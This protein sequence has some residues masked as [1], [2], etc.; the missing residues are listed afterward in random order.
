MSELSPPPK[1]I[2]AARKAA[3]ASLVGS[4]VEWYDYFIFG[5]AS[6]LVFGKLFFPESTP[7]VGTLASFAAF[8][9]GFL[10]RPLGGV[11][12]GAFGDRIGRKKILVI[13]LLI[14]GF[15]TTGIGLLPGTEQIGILAPILLVVLRLAQGFGVGGEWGGAALIAVEHAPANKKARFGSVAQMGVGIGVV[16]SAGA[17]AAMQALTTDEQFLSWGWRIP[18]LLSFVL[19]LVGFWIRRNITESPEFVELQEQG[20]ITETPVKETLTKN[21]GALW[22]ALGMRI[23]ENIFGYIVL[24]FAITYIAQN[25]DADADYVTGGIAVAG[26]TGCGTYFLAAWAS[27]KFGRRKVYIAGGVFA[28][29]YCYP[30]FLLLDTG[31]PAV[32]YLALMLGWGLA[33]GIQFGIQPAYFAELF[34]ANVRY[35]GMSIGYQVGSV[36]GGGFAPFIATAL[37]AAGGGNPI[38]VVCYMGLAAVI[39]LVAALLAKDPYRDFLTTTAPARKSV[40]R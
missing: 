27:D 26:L 37:L 10:A 24:T 30:F 11:V 5:T 3:V 20:E 33:A 38:W 18:F 4:A 34:G 15:A 32:T 13:T 9:V 1:T 36:L 31:N 14:M 17:F 12:F 28:L 22:S 7:L 25:V 16:L 19:V 39:S 40:V 35:T 6:A 23:S 8:G 29:A 21:R 2:K